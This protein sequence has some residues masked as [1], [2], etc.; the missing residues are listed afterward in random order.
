MSDIRGR[1]KG[2]EGAD[3]CHSREE[4]NKQSPETSSNT[5][6]AIRSG[7]PPLPLSD[8]SIPIGDQTATP[9][10][11]NSSEG[12]IGSL[13]SLCHEYYVEM[14]QAAA[15]YPQAAAIKE[16]WEVFN[17]W[18]DL[19]DDLDQ[20]LSSDESLRDVTVSTLANLVQIY[21]PGMDPHC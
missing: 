16:H 21:R 1:S 20:R 4:S 19:K 8:S 15:G 12:I 11:V 7:P 6:P 2:R 17:I 18:R 10:C 14:L 9:S 3:T 13:I 5:M